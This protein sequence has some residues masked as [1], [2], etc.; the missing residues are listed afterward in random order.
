[1]AKGEAT[2]AWGYY[3]LNG[4]SESARVAYGP[5]KGRW[6][7][8][9]P[10][11]QFFDLAVAGGRTP[12]YP[13]LALAPN[14]DVLAA[15]SACRRESACPHG[16]KLAWR[17]PHH[18]FGPPRLIRTAPPGAIAT[19]DAAGAAYLYSSCSGRVLIAM[20]GSHSFGKTV[21]LSPGQVSDLS[22]STSGAGE[23]LASWVTGACGDPGNA[24]GSVLASSIKGGV[25]GAPVALT[26]PSELAHNSR[27]AAVPGGGIAS[28]EVIGSAHWT[29]R[30]AGS[31]GALAAIPPESVPIVADGGGDVLFSPMELFPVPTPPQ[32]VLPR[33]GAPIQLSPSTG[34]Q[35]AAAPFARLGAAA[36]YANQRSLMLTVWRPELLP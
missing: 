11:G 30:T 12:A 8:S 32:F 2:V 35:L 34:G 10:L 31:P 21:T 14:G 33:K 13:Q 6:R 23:G 17:A 29:V 3:N 4:T 1:V 36:W 26:T 9:R 18:A 16:V 22:L 27:S 7:P 20:P 15:W 28:W 25:F 19:Y 24:P 5:L